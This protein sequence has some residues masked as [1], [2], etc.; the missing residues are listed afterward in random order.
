MKDKSKFGDS[1][2]FQLERRADM[3]SG[4]IVGGV[5]TLVCYDQWGREK[6][7]LNMHNI[8]TNVGLQHILDI[9]FVSATAQVDPWY[10]GLTDG[11]PTV[12][13]GDT[14]ASHAGWT[15]VTAYSEAVRQTYVDVRSGQSVTNTASKAVF[16][17]NGSATVGGA[18]MASSSTKGESASTLLCVVAATEGDRSVV[19]GDTINAEYTFSAADDGV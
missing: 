11:T 16:S 5:W 17:I 15:E 4:I 12:A 2:N 14:M 9:L 7:V 8:V 6:W 13:A 18:F 19:S 10:I 3:R 1:V